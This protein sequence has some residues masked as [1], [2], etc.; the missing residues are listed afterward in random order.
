MISRKL[1]WRGF[2]FVKFVQNSPKN[3][4]KSE[5]FGFFL[6]RKL[7]P[8]QTR[9]ARARTRI[10]WARQKFT[11]NSLKSEKFGFYF[12]KIQMSG[13]TFVK[14]VKIATKIC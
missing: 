6:E 2:T 1:R 8:I 14:F 12:R 5:K 4:L 13:F 7:L 10:P 11:K 9:H 3:L